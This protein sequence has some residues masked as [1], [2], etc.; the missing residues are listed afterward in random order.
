MLDGLQQRAL[1]AVADA[2]EGRGLAEEQARHEVGAALRLSPGTAGER[3]W[4]A[5]SL[6]RRLPATLAALV[7]RGHLS[8]CRPRTWSR[9]SAS[10]TTTAA[11]TVE[12]RVL[13]R[14]P[15]QTL[16]EFKRSVARAVLAV[17]PA[18]AA[19]RH[20]KAKAA[21]THRAD[22]RSRTAMES[23][24]G[25]PCPPRSRRDRGPP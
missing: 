22:A 7:R 23:L 21:R 2:T 25:R 11:S 16:A 5:T 14:A 24:L 13:A 3:T 6:R 15:E 20:Q 10:S 18:S 1:C 17:D 8:T 19:D 12:A 4:V 9:R